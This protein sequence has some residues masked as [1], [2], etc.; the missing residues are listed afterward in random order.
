MNLKPIHKAVKDYYVA[1]DQF[2]RLGITH[3][4]AVRSACQYLLESCARQEKWTLITEYSMTGLR[5]KRISVDGA[6]FDEFELPRGYWEAKDMDDDL[7]TEIRRKFDKGYPRDNIL[8]QTPERA[9]LWQNE[10]EVLDADL[11]DPAQLVEVVRTFFA[12][13]PPEYTEWEEAVAH[14]K[15]RVPDI[16]SELADLIQKERDTNPR[17]TGAFR[18]FHEKCCQSINSPKPPLRRC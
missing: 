17:F 15:D 2:A 3:E 6:L 13:R 16:G 7:P 8:F 9:I 18:T 10:R 4:G 5:N 11:T 12:Y 1:L 14:F